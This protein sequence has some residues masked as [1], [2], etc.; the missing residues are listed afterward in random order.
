MCNCIHELL[1]VFEDSAQRE[2]TIGLYNLDPKLRIGKEDCFNWLEEPLLLSFQFQ[3]LQNV[4]K[5]QYIA[6]LQMLLQVYRILSFKFSNQTISTFHSTHTFVIDLIM[7][8]V[9]P[10]YT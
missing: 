9:V 6:C 10:H 8:E 3:L 2:R 7:P 1:N 4:Y 5:H